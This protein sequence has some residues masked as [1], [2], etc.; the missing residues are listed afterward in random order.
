[1]QQK[2]VKQISLIGLALSAGAL[3]LLPLFSHA[4]GSEN[5]TAS[6]TLTGGIIQ[7]ISPDDFAFSPIFLPNTAGGTLHAYKTLFPETTGNIV[8]VQDADNGN[9][10]FKATMSITNFSSG[11]GVIPFTSF[12]ILTLA[13]NT[14]DGVDGPDPAINQ[15]TA[16]W[17]CPWNTQSG[18][19]SA[20]CDS[21]FDT[22]GFTGT[23]PVLLSDPGAP[24]LE[25]D[26]IIPVRSSGDYAAGDVI[27]FNSGEYGVVTS[28]PG[29]AEIEVVRGVSGSTAA[30]QA[31]FSTIT[32]MGQSSSQIDIIVAP[33][34]V[35][36]RIGAYSVGFGIRTLLEEKVQD[37]GAYSGQITFTLY[38]CVDLSCI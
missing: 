10:N 35:G 34:P 16:P 4:Q 2:N 21:I 26:T 31:A 27:R 15:V 17:G 24:I 22:S 13:T 14:V 29:P 19:L 12:A 30:P 7:L 9:L 33:E 23:G 36:G 25:T 20:N 37:P 38:Q 11:A 28:I 1:M 18:T 32:N 6:F 3:L 8:E 5:Q